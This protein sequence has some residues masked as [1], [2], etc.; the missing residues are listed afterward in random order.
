MPTVFTHPV[1]P[2]AL[3]LGLGRDVVSRPLLVAGVIASVLPD[4]DVLAFRFGIS[5][6]S[7]FGHRG[8]SHSLLFAGLIAGLGM[9]IAP[10]LRT[11]RLVAFV[12][13][14][15]ATASHGLLDACTT[16][17]KGV[18]LFWPWSDERLFAPFRTI[19]VS[20]L[21]LSRFFSPRGWRTINSELFWV[22]TPGVA[23][24]LGLRALRWGWERRRIG[25]EACTD[26]DSA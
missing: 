3:G 2:L 5:Y 18:A 23:L 4:L 7:L 1:V 13:L 15:V 12:F 8:F 22:W 19:V 6:A 9:A 26:Q 25:R 17:G 20:P 16:G 11:T 24:A 10:R 14:F 21:D